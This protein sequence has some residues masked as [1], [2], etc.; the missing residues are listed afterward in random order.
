MSADKRPAI[1]VP[2]RINP[3]V[4]ERVEAEFDAIFDRQAG[5]GSLMDTDARTRILGVAV[6]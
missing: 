3:R 5:F 2:G 4:R 6:A 1:L